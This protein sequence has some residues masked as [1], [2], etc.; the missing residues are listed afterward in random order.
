VWSFA[1]PAGKGSIQLFFGVLLVIQQQS[2]GGAIALSALK[3]RKHLL[4]FHGE[5]AGPG[6][7]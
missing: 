1:A 2:S 3:T 6:P 5:P 4:L 7:L